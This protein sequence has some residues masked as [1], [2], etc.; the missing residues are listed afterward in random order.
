MFKLESYITPVILSYVEKYVK[1]FKPEQSQVSRV[2]FYFYLFYLFIF[3]L[4]YFFILLIVSLYIFS[5]IF[6]MISNR[7]I[8]IFI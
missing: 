7:T 6:V 4:F 5:V 1:N 2:L 8:S 3:I